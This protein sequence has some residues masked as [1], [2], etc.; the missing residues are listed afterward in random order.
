MK[1]S[2]EKM[3][4]YFLIAVI[5]G[6][7]LIYY[8][9]P[10]GE[11]KTDTDKPD[12]NTKDPNKKSTGGSTGR[13]TIAG[14]DKATITVIQEHINFARKGREGYQITADGIWGKKT[15]EA[16]KS[17]WRMD[18]SDLTYEEFV[19]RREKP[20]SSASKDTIKSLQNVLNQTPIMLAAKRKVNVDGGYGKM[21]KD[22]A[23]FVLGEDIS[24][25]TFFEVLNM[26]DSKVKISTN[27]NQSFSQTVLNKMVTNPVSK[28]F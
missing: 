12:P 27:P 21:T 16:A 3:L 9:R 13:K 20:I 11:Q 19:D 24:K 17:T 18:I 28:G 25:R 5:I 14:E 6:A 26:I 7:S 1:T 8:F 4:L 22:A 23:M 10:K 2:K 15:Q